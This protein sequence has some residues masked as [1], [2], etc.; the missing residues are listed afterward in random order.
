MAAS[1]LSG[2]WRWLF[3]MP[4]FLY[5]WRLGWL[6]GHRF[7]L[8]IHLGR[9][10]GLRRHTVLEVMEY[11]AEGPEA[12]VM[13]AFSRSA[14]WLR[15]IEATPGPEVVIGSL[16]FVAAHRFF[17]QEEAMRVII[18]YERRNWI[19]AP[20]IRMVLSRLAGWQ[21]DGSGGAR[22]RLVAQLPLIA[23]RPANRSDMIMMPEAA[24]GVADAV[25]DRYF[26]VNHK[27]SRRSQCAL[28]AREGG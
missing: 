16:H 18:G 17:D 22:R 5:R 26:A 28:H 25:A 1:R 4:A 20:I 21:Y 23:F 27:L 11:R 12:V 19:I 2:T 24:D 7:L 6:L 8:L 13:S 14:D 3:R 10:T 9:R 15:N